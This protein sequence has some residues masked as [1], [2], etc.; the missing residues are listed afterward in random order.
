VVSGVTEKV[1]ESKFESD[2]G[3]AGENSSMIGWSDCA[4]FGLDG[5]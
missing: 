4:A 5:Q 2:D 3:M 1:P